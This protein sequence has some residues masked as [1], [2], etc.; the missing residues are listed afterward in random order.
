MARIAGKWTALLAGVALIGLMP[1]APG[2]CAG[3]DKAGTPADRQMAETIRK[4]EEQIKQLQAEINRLRGDG[5][6]TTVRQQAE[7]TSTI[8]E[9]ALRDSWGGGGTDSRE[10]KVHDGTVAIKFGNIF[11]LI[12]F[13]DSGAEGHARADHAIFLK[14]SGLERGAIEYYSGKKK[15]YSISGSLAE[16]KVV[17]NY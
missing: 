2:M 8:V 10:I 17:Q 3:G 11:D 9:L 5:S 4:Q 12:G 13:F 6:T 15:L 14:S 7:D 16:A 1:A